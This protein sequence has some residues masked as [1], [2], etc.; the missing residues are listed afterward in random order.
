M[1]KYFYIAGAI[2]VL[3]GAFGWPF[4]LKVNIICKNQY[5]DCPEPVAGELGKFSGENLFKAGADVKKNLKSNYLVSDFSLQFRLPNILLVNLIT[6]KASFALVNLASG[7]ALIDSTGEVVAL[8]KD[9]TL[10]KVIVNEELPK[11]GQKVSDSDLMALKLIEGVFEMYQVNSGQVQDGTLTVDLP[12]QIRVLF[13]LDGEDPRVL[14]GALR[15]IYTRVT[16]AEAAGKYSEIDLR[17]KNPVI[18]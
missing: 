18:R 7:A 10:P 15:L 11:A 14:L 16:S 4:F 5:G 9:T 13:P 12:A 17:F 6:K 1:R 8:A 3:A 2:L